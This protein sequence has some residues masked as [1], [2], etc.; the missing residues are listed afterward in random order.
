MNEKQPLTKR[1]LLKTGVALPVTWTV[2]APL[3]AQA[4]AKSSYKVII[5]DMLDVL[6]PKDISPSATELKVH[7][8]IWEQARTITNYE[9]MLRQGVSW[10]DQQALR[11]GSSSGYVGLTF[12]QKNQ[13]VAAALTNPPMA[14]P[15]VFIG[16][17]ME[18]AFRFYYMQLE[19]YKHIKGMTPIQPLGYPRHHRL[20]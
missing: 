7:E 4:Q 14:L 15:R 16:R 17:L 20:P 12:V 10:L 1:C 6:I 18:D 8:K 3:W 13:Y 9:T 19:A 11:N 5:A 2:A